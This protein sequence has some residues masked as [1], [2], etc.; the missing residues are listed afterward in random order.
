MD[1]F[2]PPEL[3]GL[4]L[5]WIIKSLSL[6]RKRLKGNGAK[7]IYSYIAHGVL[8]GNALERIQSS[9]IEALVLTDSISA[10]ESVKSAKN[11]RLIS[12]APLMGEAIKRINSDSSVSALFD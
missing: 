11:I 1:V 7:N 2:S 3:K 5:S 8:S 4:S 10:S 12:I 6:K 9:E